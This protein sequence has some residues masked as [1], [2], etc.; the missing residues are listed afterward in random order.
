[1]LINWQQRHFQ[2]K[3]ITLSAVNNPLL[4]AY[5]VHVSSQKSLLSQYVDAAARKCAASNAAT[6]IALLQSALL[7][8][9]CAAITSTVTVTAAEPIR[10]PDD[11]SN[12]RASSGV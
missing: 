7:I 1:M 6:A 12:D 5:I 4:F 8:A 11:D 10:S 9:L 3:Q 2:H